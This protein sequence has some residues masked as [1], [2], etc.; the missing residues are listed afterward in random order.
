MSFSNDTATAPAPVSINVMDVVRG[1]GRRWLMITAIGVL[2]GAGSTAFVNYM[3][4]VYSTETLILVQNLETPYDRVQAQDN[5]RNDAVDDRVIASQM[6]VVKSADLGRRVIAALG[7]EQVPE[8]NPLLKGVGTAGAL[9]LALGF[10]E[11]PRMKTPE[12]RAFDRY[13]GQLSVYQQPQS[14]VIAIKYAA[15]DPE[16]AAKV[17]NTLAETY[18]TW[19]RESQSQ[20]TERARDWLS[21]QIDDLRKKLSKSEEAVE[22]FR[23]QAGLLQGTTSTLGTQ[24]ISE[25][26]TQI[27]V[28]MAARSDARARADAIGDLLASKGSVDSSPDVL[29]SSVVQRLKE[30]RADAAR[31]VAELSATYLPNHPRMM[32]AQSQLTNLDRQM[33]AEAL[34]VVTSL[35]DQ[36]MVAEAREKSL[37]ESLNELKTQK[38]TANLD[39]VKLKALEREAGAG[40]MLLESLLSRYAEANAR[41]DQ[42]FQPGLARIIQSASVPVAPSFPKRGPMVLLI[43]MAGLS[44]GIGMAFLIELMGAASRLTRPVVVLQDDAAEPQEYAMQVVAAQPGPAVAADPAAAGDWQPPPLYPPVEPLAELPRELNQLQAPMSVQ[45]PQVVAAG[46]KLAAWVMA[47]AGG[48]RLQRIGIASIGGGAGETSMA[49]VAL[50]RALAAAGKRVVVADLSR[51]GSWILGISGVLPGAGFADLVSG[52]AS[53]TKVIGRDVK[54]PIHILR[55]G[56]D[57]SEKATTLIAE[58]ADGVFTALAQSYDVVIVNLGEAQP[59]TPVYLHKCEAALILAPAKRTGDAAEAVNVLLQ[60]GLRAARSVE[61]GHPLEYEAGNPVSTLAASA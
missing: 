36:A 2:S 7:L 12:Q 56:L 25:L 18:V 21:Q 48:A 6:S 33:R 14:N 4:P 61:I 22:R 47:G 29:A 34:K 17:A 5:T 24:E 1:V 55:Y 32:A 20:P 59:D 60:T 10:G 37:R 31:T 39:D 43:T 19:T 51:T 3:K 40:R 52:T 41:Q 42:S 58:R 11:D 44:L 49:A 54:S 26:N 9:K 15:H 45:A 35:E 50:A 13:D 8:F 16:I 57:H 28:A 23:A 53:F 27:T 30:Q 38:S 46:Q